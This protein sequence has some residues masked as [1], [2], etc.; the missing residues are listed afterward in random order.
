[1]MFHDEHQKKLLSTVYQSPSVLKEY[2]LRNY[3]KK[4]SPNIKFFF[5][6]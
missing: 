2:A 1:M 6:T 3:I 4:D 5:K